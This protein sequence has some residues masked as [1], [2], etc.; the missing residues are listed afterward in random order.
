MIKF[1]AIFLIITVYFFQSSATE[2]E[3]FITPSII[4]PSKANVVGIEREEKINENV[5]NSWQALTGFTHQTLQ[6]FQQGNKYGIIYVHS[7]EDIMGVK[8]AFLH[9]W[10]LNHPNDQRSITRED[11]TDNFHQIVNNNEFIDNYIEYV[12]AARPLI[13]GSIIALHEKPIHTVADTFA[14]ISFILD[15]PPEC[16]AVTST[17]DARTPVKY[18]HEENPDAIATIKRYL[19]SGYRS[20][21]QTLD[22]LIR[23]PD[24]TLCTDSTGKLDPERGYATMN[25]VAILSCA[26]IKDKD[27]R[28]K[29][30][31]VL[32]NTDFVSDKRDFGNAS[33]NETWKDAAEA[34]S[35]KNNLPL[36][37]LEKIQSVLVKDIE[38]KVVKEW[39]NEPLSL[40]EYYH[41]RFS[42]VNETDPDNK[43][44]WFL[45]SDEQLEQYHLKR[46]K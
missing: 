14:P 19:N 31:G 32:Y 10:N 43:N 15:V 44:N 22:S 3:N 39:F 16:V 6:N 27:Y 20:P 21:I 25:E 5:Q 46:I 8:D 23:Y 40:P 24:F 26:K 30:V 29:I 45:L 42:K 1:V 12:L 13:S 2:N 41:F 17:T 9:N 35:K 33:R 11:G 36:L 18:L 4:I 38:E 37:T 34:F 28:P 7:V